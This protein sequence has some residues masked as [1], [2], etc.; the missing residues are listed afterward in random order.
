MK[1]FEWWVVVGGH[2]TRLRETP[3]NALDTQKRI[4]VTFKKA[5]S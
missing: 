3:K 4:F 2:E 1:M 5:F